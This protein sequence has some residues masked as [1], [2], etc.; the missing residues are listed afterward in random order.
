VSWVLLLI[1]LHGN[2][3]ID[4]F[5]TKTECEIIRELNTIKDSKKYSCVKVTI[6]EKT[7]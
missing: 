5:P 4:Y 6:K 2:V 7:K 1:T 3:I